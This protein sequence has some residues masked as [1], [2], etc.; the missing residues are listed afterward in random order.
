MKQ[1]IRYPEVGYYTAELFEPARWKPNYPNLAFEQMDDADGYW[2][3]KIVSAFT[4]DM[5]RRL[6]ENGQYSRAEVTAYV[7]EVLRA[8]Q[9]AIG[10]YW[11]N[12]VAPIEDLVLEQAGGKAAVRFRDLALERGYVEP[13]S[14]LYRFFVEDGKGRLLQP[15]SLR[16]SRGDLPLAA[17]SSDRPANAQ[18]D[19]YGRIPLYTVTIQTNRTDGGWSLPLEA[20]LGLQQGKPGLHILG[21]AHAPR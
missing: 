3:A 9:Q 18:S 1:E 6:V 10:H 16:S 13:Q 2:G 5:I 8:R 14:R 21:W 11:F 19:R 17:L 12:R 15:G 4:A 7:A 20:V